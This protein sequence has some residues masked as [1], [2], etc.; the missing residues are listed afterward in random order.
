MAAIRSRHAKADFI[1]HEEESEEMI[2]S[3]VLSESHHGN[4]EERDAYEMDQ[5][6][7]GQGDDYESDTSE[8]SQEN[9]EPA[10]LEDIEKFQ[11][12][13][14]GISDRFRLI[15]RIG[16]GGFDCIL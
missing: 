6:A 9:I 2:G 4:G 8:D 1:I 16:E 10:V 12:T 7:D 13:F 14:A 3:E 15:S 11:A 5:E